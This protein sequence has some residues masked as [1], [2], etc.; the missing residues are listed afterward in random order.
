MVGDSFTG[1][2]KRPSRD[3]DHKVLA[4]NG[5]NGNSWLARLMP[6]GGRYLTFRLSAICSML[7]DVS[8]VKAITGLSVVVCCVMSM[9][10]Y[11]VPLHYVMAC[12]VRFI[13]WGIEL[14]AELEQLK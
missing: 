11:Y 6:C 8:S 5:K 7:F 10:P 14:I 3:H 4:P 2:G 9:T 13:L 12:L 1:A